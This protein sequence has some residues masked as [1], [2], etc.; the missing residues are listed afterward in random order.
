MRASCHPTYNLGRAPYKSRNPCLKVMELPTKISS[1][2]A[3]SRAPAWWLGLLVERC[4][5]TKEGGR[6]DEY[7][8]S[9]CDFLVSCREKRTRRKGKVDSARVQNRKLTEKFS[10]AYDASIS[11]LE[12]RNHNLYVQSIQQRQ[13]LHLMEP[14][15][16]SLHPNFH[17]SK[18]KA[19]GGGGCVLQTRLLPASSQVNTDLTS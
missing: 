3:P 16:P 14:P 19:V 1:L 10:P 4:L 5:L 7:W 6:E 11:P 2:T 9:H 13:H 12:L 18:Q 17:L 8:L 15:L